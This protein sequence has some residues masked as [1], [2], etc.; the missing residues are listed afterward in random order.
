MAVVDFM[1]QTLD[2]IHRGVPGAPEGLTSE[3]VHFVPE[4]QSHR[5]RGACG[6]RPA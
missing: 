2:F 5:S 6:M 1:K 4:G 3:Q